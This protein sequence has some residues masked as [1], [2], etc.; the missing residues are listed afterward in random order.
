MR[1]TVIFALVV[2]L[3][4]CG[5]SAPKGTQGPPP[6]TS[7]GRPDLSHPEVGPRVIVTMSDSAIKLSHDT[8]TS[9]G[10]GQITFAVENKGAGT[11][12]LEID[13]GES[14][15]WTTTPIPDNQTVLMSMLMNRGSYQL[16]E[17]RPDTAGTT[18]RTG[19]KTTIIIE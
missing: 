14:G 6:D 19:L 15:K 11:K 17:M 9:V 13:G 12:V 2:A 4:G 1:N 8:V 18:K 10:T 3:A 5:D 16:Y 7:G